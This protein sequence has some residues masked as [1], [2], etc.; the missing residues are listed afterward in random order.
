MN[1]IYTTET[2]DTKCKLILRSVVG[3]R[4]FGLATDT[5]DTDVKGVYIA[6]LM[7][8]I[9]YGMQD[10]V[11]DERNNT[12]YWEISKYLDLLRRANPGALELLY[13]PEHCV[14][15]R[16][17]LFDLI[18]RREFLTMKCRDTFLNYAMS[19]V[20]RA[21]GMNKKVFSPEPENEP[22]VLDF[23]YVWTADG[24]AVPVKRILERM[25]ID[26]KECAV[27]AVNHMDNTYSV[28]RQSE[29][30]ETPRWAYGIVRDETKSRDLQMNSIPKGEK[31]IF[32]MTYN[33]NGYSL[34]CKRHAE[35]WYWVKHRNDARYAATVSQGNGYD[36]KNMMHTIRLLM[37][38]KC[39][40]EKHTLQVDASENR[41]FLLSIKNGK[42]TYDDA[43]KTADALASEVDA[44]FA[45]SGLPEECPDIDDIL[46]SIV[47]KSEQIW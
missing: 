37:S 21:R 32:C 27:S 5:S 14:F 28:Y 3:S 1:P 31:P 30:A 39:I 26:Q 2:I 4:S 15:I 43:L 42:M 45:K 18:P 10:Q 47:T 8:R 23:C 20:H 35:Y 29:I 44:A 12:V 46:K 17:P 25:G 16:D 6:P 24:T 36:A 40:A 19:Q 41:E 22:A 13:S 11:N 7:D 9:G 33:R 38:A 34:A